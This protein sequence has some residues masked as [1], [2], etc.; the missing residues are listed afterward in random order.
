[1]PDAVPGL[2]PRA[3]EG[4]QYGQKWSLSYCREVTIKRFFGVGL[5][6]GQVDWYR[7]GV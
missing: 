3:N 4:G 7:W 6:W 2:I 1:M 5:G